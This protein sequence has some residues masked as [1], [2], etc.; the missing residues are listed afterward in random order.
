MVVFDQISYV[1]YKM[2]GIVATT[3]KHYNGSKVRWLTFFYSSVQKLMSGFLTISI[4]WNYSN[5]A[6]CALP[7]T[8]L[9]TNRWQ[10]LPTII[11]LLLKQH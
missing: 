6:F 1:I 10:P 4:L 2:Q 11:K 8:A 7:F 3:A 9:L 5:T